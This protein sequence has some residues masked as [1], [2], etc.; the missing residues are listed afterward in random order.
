MKAFPNA[1]VILT[2]RDPEKWY[3]SVSNTIG[4]IRKRMTPVMKAFQ[5]L[6][7]HLPLLQL[8]TK[9]QN[10]PDPITEKGR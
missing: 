1:K 5:F 7:G 2:L 9:L 3:D 4:L 6:N 8:V 10:Y